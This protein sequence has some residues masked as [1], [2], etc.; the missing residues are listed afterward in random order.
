MSL[1][2]NVS[3]FSRCTRT[4]PAGYIKKVNSPQLI[5]PG[6]LSAHPPPGAGAEPAKPM[7]HPHRFSCRF[8]LQSWSHFLPGNVCVA[9]E[10]CR[11]EVSLSWPFL[12]WL[13]IKT[14]SALDSHGLT[15]PCNDA[16]SKAEAYWC[17]WYLLNALLQ[18]LPFASAF[19]QV[20]YRYASNSL[21]NGL[22][23][24]NLF[25][26]SARFVLFWHL[27]TNLETQPKL[28]P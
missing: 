10:I 18:H 12:A 2:L 20:A 26:F 23:L 3:L 11:L 19:I 4:Q 5:V 21:E 8:Y 24:K 7:D 28:K 14:S 17:K 25:Y 27:T 1:L 22:S 9:V 16:V 15:S 13:W 6:S